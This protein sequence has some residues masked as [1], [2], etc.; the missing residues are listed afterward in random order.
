MRIFKFHLILVLPSEL[1]PTLGVPSN[2]HNWDAAL[3]RSFYFS[4]HNLCRL[5]NEVE[6]LVDFDLVEW[7][8][9]SLVGQAFLQV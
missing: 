1:R 6:A 3:F 8:Y 4:I 2:L 7:D 5:F 9:E